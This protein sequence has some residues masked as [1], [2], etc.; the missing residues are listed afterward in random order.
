MKNRWFVLALAIVVS[1]LILVGVAYATAH[2]TSHQN[3][4]IGQQLKV[5]KTGEIAFDQPTKI[6]DLV[7]PPGPYRFVHRAAG[8][9][10]F[11]KFTQTTGAGR[12][13]GV[14]KC[15]IEALP[16]KVSRTAITTTDDSGA[17]RITRI[18]VAGE[19]VAHI[20]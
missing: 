5:G 9:A 1:G 2:E 3:M 12:D 8:D 10:H 11:V 15:R 4:P 20:F 17:R 19:N 18:E 7:L 6:G 13:V 16:K 14:I